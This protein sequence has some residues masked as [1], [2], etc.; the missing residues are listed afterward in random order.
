[1]NEEIRENLRHLKSMKHIMTKVIRPCTKDYLISK[2]SV[3]EDTN[4]LELLYMEFNDLTYPVK[5]G[6][7]DCDEPVDFISF[8]NGFKQGCCRVHS[9]KVSFLKRFGVENPSQ[10]EDVKNK[11]NK[12]IEEKYGVDNYFKSNKFKED[13][14]KS[15]LEK[16][17]VEHITQSD[18]FK[19][20]SKQTCLEKYGVDNYFKAD[21]FKEDLKK[22]NL[23]KYG[24]E[25]YSQTDV[26]KEKLKQTSLKRYGVESPNQAP[27][28]IE[29]QAQTMLKK[30][31]FRS[32]FSKE[33]RHVI[34]ATWLKNHGVKHPM[35]N[36][37]IV[38]KIR[39]TTME[40][41]GVPHICFHPPIQ[42]KK[43]ETNLR[44][45]GHKSYFGS[46]KSKM[47][48]RARLKEQYGVSNISQKHLKNFEHWNDAN[49]IEETFLTKKKYFEYE[50]FCRYFNCNQSTAH[51]RLIILQIDYK[52]RPWSEGV[53][54]MEKEVSDYIKSLIDD[55]V[56]ENDRS[57][58]KGKELDILI[59]SRK[60]AIEFN[61]IFWHVESK[62]K[63][64]NYHL[65]KTERC[66]E[67]AIEL[68]HISDSEW[69]FKNEI[70]KSFL[71]KK[72]N[73]L[74]EVD[75]ANGS[76]I[77]LS[78]ETAFDFFE[79]NSLISLKKDFKIEKALGVLFEDEIVFVTVSDGEFL[80]YCSKIDI[81]IDEATIIKNLI[82]EDLKIEIDRRFPDFDLIQTMDLELV[83][84]EEPN[85]DFVLI[86][87]SE[88]KF[89]DCGKLIFS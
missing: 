36:P 42:K 6:Y 21:K 69:M 85:F 32:N 71:K 62:G 68:I 87:G 58:L 28:K 64:K 24:V 43:E 23:E 59:P 81:R 15:N 22:S 86:E 72:L 35:Q 74:E 39:K 51:A 38:E 27:E 14:K 53:S 75:L 18:H 20:K 9:Q 11:R 65:S 44:L 57:I 8:K 34:E 1:M 60:L 10:L 19:E 76:Y 54:L 25:H 79:E 4:L 31:G 88:D 49:F 63:D 52:K 2:F 66:L 70:I 89:W 80:H 50:K 77:E 37:K 82:E 47:E 56:I 3:P 40:K 12:T 73:V 61:G 84:I 45:Y 16:Y 48:V 46:E 13:L 67:E 83:Q 55:E 33:N 5:C 30:Y 7:K 17:G 26:C 29:K 78:E 41:Y